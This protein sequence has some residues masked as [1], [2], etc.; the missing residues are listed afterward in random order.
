MLDAGGKVFEGGIKEAVSNYLTR[1]RQISSVPLVSSVSKGNGKVR[2][3]GFRLESAAGTPLHVIRSGGEAVFCFDFENVACSPAEKVS[4]SF[5]VYNDKEFGLFHYYSHFS[6]VYFTDMPAKSTVR[7]RLPHVDLAPGNY[8]LTIYT[9]VAGDLADWPQ[10]FL[11][12]TVVASDFYG[13]GDPNLSTW[14]PMLVKGEW[15]L[16]GS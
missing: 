16:R 6:G 5:G 7:C 3:V 2:A 15:S 14:G 4:V 1:S 12:L 10:A 11:P 9:R 13:T 8:L